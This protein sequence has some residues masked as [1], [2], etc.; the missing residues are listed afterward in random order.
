MGQTKYIQQSEK[1]SDKIVVN[2]TKRFLLTSLPVSIAVVVF[3]AV[4]FF[5]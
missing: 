5:S 1:Y 2:R 3:Y 4:K